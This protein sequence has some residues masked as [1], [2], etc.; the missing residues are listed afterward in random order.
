MVFSTAIFNG[1]AVFADNVVTATVQADDGSVGDTINVKVTIPEASQIYSGS[2][3]LVYDNSKLELI[4]AEAGTI[5]KDRMQIVNTNFAK[6]N[7][8]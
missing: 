8:P 6:G 3:E 2:F 5:I 1:A 4:S 7:G